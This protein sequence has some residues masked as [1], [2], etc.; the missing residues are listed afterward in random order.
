MTWK[1]KLLAL[2]KKHTSQVQQLKEE[3]ERTNYHD[4]FERSQQLVRELQAQLDEFYAVLD[5]LEN[6]EKLQGA[7][8]NSITEAHLQLR[9]VGIQNADMRKK[10]LTDYVSLKKLQKTV[11]SDVDEEHQDLVEKCSHLTRV[12]QISSENVLQL[13]TLYTS[14]SSDLQTATALVHQLNSEL[15]GARKDDQQEKE[16][17]V[18]E[19][20]QA[21]TTALMNL[22]K[23]LHTQKKLTQEAELKRLDAEARMQENDSKYEELI[24][25]L[26]RTIDFREHDSDL[27]MKDMEMF[28]E[29]IQQQRCEIDK[30]VT[31]RHLFEDKIKHYE[32]NIMTLTKNAQFM[33]AERDL[34]LMSLRESEEKIRTLSLELNRQARLLS[35]SEIRCLQLQSTVQSLHSDLCASKEELESTRSHARKMLVHQG[36]E[37]RDCGHAIENLDLR[38]K[39]ILRAMKRKVGIEEDGVKAEEGSVDTEVKK[40]PRS[41]V[42]AV[43]HAVNSHT[44]EPTENQ[45]FTE[46]SLD[47][48]WSRGRPQRSLSAPLVVPAADSDSANNS[49]SSSNQSD[50]SLPRIK[51][52]FSNSPSEASRARLGYSQS[53]AFSPVK[54]RTALKI[55]HDSYADDDQ[56]SLCQSEGQSPSVD[57]SFTGLQVSSL[58]DQILTLGEVLGEI[59]RMANIVERAS[60]LSIQDLKGEDMVLRERIEQLESH[61]E[62][63]QAE[64]VLKDAELSTASQDVARLQNR[65]KQMVTAMMDMSDQQ[66]QIKKLKTEIECLMN[67]MKRVEGEKHIIAEQCEKLIQQLETKADGHTGNLAEVRSLREV[68]TLKKENN[69]LRMNLCEEG[70]RYQEMVK[71]AARKIK[72][73]EDNWKKAEAEVFRFDELVETIQKMLEDNRAV[74]ESN[75]SLAKLL[76]IVSGE[77]VEGFGISPQNKETNGNNSSLLTP[78]TWSFLK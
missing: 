29:T 46:S 51:L 42:S 20:I 75:E 26:Q 38:M 58:V 50:H 44:S 25:N 9:C 23:D 1:Q 28:Q 4:Q 66:S 37:L 32:D 10:L 53:S 31:G 67:Q 12:A 13:Q 78:H 70:D 35:D 30:Y 49:Q 21:L 36:L 68:I 77:D 56:A 63:L 59:V 16:K 11:T 40:A 27:L 60:Q 41:L 5:E 43:L 76:Q 74:I 47:L 45:S 55:K 73:L 33:E 48:T 65:I 71:R 64:I 52:S 54:S 34:L 22:E 61:T 3:Y 72:I 17:S 69:Q 6:T 62:H 19:E 57:G 14:T 18:L 8:Q 15:A 39:C 24:I 7:L 2:E